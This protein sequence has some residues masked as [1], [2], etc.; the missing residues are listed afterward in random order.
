MMKLNSK[1]NQNEIKILLEQN[2]KLMNT[3][4]FENNEW[5]IG[6]SPQLLLENFQN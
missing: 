5:W 2:I 4:M 3:L 1:N 6:L